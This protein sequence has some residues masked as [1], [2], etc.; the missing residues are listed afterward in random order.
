MC[1][2]LDYLSAQILDSVQL[3]NND[4]LAG[5]IEKNNMDSFLWFWVNVL[6]RTLA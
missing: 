6:Q 3:N 5:E 4:T 1:E 2:V